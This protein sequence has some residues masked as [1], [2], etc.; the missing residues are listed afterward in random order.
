MTLNVHT[1]P[2]V[3]PKSQGKSWF[4]AKQALAIDYHVEEEEVRAVASELHPEG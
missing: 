2:P 4:V 3:V 1:P